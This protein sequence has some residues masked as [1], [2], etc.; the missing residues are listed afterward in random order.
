MYIEITD[1]FSL[2]KI[3][4][5]GQCFRAKLLD[6]GTW[7]FITGSSILHIRLLSHNRYEIDCTASQWLTV[8][9]PY[10]DLDRDYS[11]IRSRIAQTDYYMKNAADTGAG[12]R[13]L[14]QDPWEML[15]TF[16]ISQQKNIPSIKSCVEKIAEK[17]GDKVETPYGTVHFFPS[18]RQMSY[19][20][21][22]ELNQC[23]LGYRTPY[24]QDAINKVASG[25]LDLNTLY[26][27]GDM[28]LF[29]AL[30]SVHG[31]GDKVANC[32]ALFAYSR[33]SLVPVDTWIRKVIDGVYGGQN[34]FTKYGSD[35]G[36]MQQYIF[37]YVQHNKKSL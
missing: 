1:D 7:R 16:I 13:I 8:W 11:F 2:P 12:L 6:D 32:I 4:E 25:Q 19:I 30:K 34:P 21:D 20:T 18:A 27:Y 37:Y 10:F 28:Q 36:I 26:S 3:A 33:T 9:L 14:R 23:K 22:E 5:S 35:A 31:V 15:I 29:N 24:I 17:Y